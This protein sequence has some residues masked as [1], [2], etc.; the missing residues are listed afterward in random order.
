[1]APVY[2]IAVTI[3]YSW[4]LLRFSWRLPSFLK[5]STNSEIGVILAYLM[6]VTL[7]ESLVVVLAPIVLSIIL[8]QKWF[9]DRFITKGALLVSLWLGYLIYIAG[10]IMPEMPFPYTLIKWSPVFFLL[11]LIFVLLLG[12]IKFLSK[13]VDDI[14]DRFVVFLYISIPVS[15]I[16]L[17]V[18]LIRNIL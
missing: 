11:I 6:V 3:V 5:Y 12:E 16:S 10:K 8:P 9:H 14:S 2:A 18:V 17:M 4:S 1:L 7:L 15:A 13:I